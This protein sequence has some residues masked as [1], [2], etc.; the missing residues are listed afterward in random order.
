MT[1]KIFIL[2]PLML[3]A[4]ATPELPGGFE[5]EQSWF[6]TRVERGASAD[7]V[8]AAIPD[9]RPSISTEQLRQSAGE[10]LEARDEVSADERAIRESDSDTEAF[11]DAARQRAEPPPHI[12]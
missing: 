11:A 6:D 9:K 10:V 7:N 2:G 3:A 12:D 5:E 4:C 1:R 8:P